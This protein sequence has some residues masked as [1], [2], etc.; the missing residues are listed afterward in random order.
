M[1]EIENGLM[2]S[3]VKQ[4]VRCPCYA[5]VAVIIRM[6]NGKPKMSNDTFYIDVFVT[7]IEKN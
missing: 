7:F 5:S 2:L 6:D 1:L 4:A 3:P